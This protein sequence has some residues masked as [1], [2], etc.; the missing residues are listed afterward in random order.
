[1]PAESPGQISVR[2]RFGDMQVVND[3]QDTTVVVPAACTKM[4]V[5]FYTPDQTIFYSL[6]GAASS[7]RALPPPP[8]FHA[9][10]SYVIGVAGGATVYFRKAYNPRGD[11]SIHDG[12]T[13]ALFPDARMAMADDKIAKLL[14]VFN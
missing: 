12:V 2:G 11:K 9:T 8:R 6:T 7:W 4:E 5:H 1:M 14:V 3:A 10:S 13:G